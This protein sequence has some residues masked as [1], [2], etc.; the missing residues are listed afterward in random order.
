MELTEQKNNGGPMRKFQ[1]VTLLG[2]AV[3]SVYL[4]IAGDHVEPICE[5]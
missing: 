3:E 5:Q 1:N 4:I 2:V